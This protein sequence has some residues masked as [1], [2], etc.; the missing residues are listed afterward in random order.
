M[1]REYGK[2]GVG[3]YKH[4]RCHDGPSGT[5]CAVCRAGNAEHYREAVARR[6][7][8][9]RA[10]PGLRPHGQVNTY[11]NWGCHCGECREAW[12]NRPRKTQH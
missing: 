5:A 2:H 4:G 9:L 1:H 11:R 12:R 8:R 6:A 7:A 3:R 10:N